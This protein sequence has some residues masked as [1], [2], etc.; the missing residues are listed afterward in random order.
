MRGQSADRG[1]GFGQN[2]DVQEIDV[3]IIVFHS[4]A[5]SCCC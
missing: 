1:D 5:I 4:I 2:A 3:Y